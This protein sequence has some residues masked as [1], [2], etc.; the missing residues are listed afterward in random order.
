MLPFTEEQF[1]SVFA[2]YNQAVWPAQWVLTAAALGIVLLSTSRAAW[3]DRA[4]CLLLA[5]L[6]AWMGIA[7]HLLH[8]SRINS[9]A[10]AF[11]ALYLVE[12]ALF[13]WWAL[14][15]RP[16]ELRYRSDPPSALGLA[17]LAYSLV[18][19]PLLGRWLGHAYPASPTFGVPCPTTIFTLGILALA[20]AKDIVALAAVPLLWSAVGG[21]A[22]FLLGVWQDL[23][24]IVSGIAL[25]SLLVVRRREHSR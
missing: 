20:R 13:A 15:G 2:E 6:W 21:S 9:A 19:Y 14:A 11:G 5:G 17:M 10:F 1:F 16:L 22:A 8:F 24:L 23:G 7:Y 3:K 18:A 25:A 12:A 4:V